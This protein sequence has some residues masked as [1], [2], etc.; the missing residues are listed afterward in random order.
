MEVQEVRPAPAATTTDAVVSALLKKRRT[1]GGDNKGAGGAAGDKGKKKLKFIAPVPPPPSLR[2]SIVAGGGGSS[3][4]GAST[5]GGSSTSTS[6]R[7]SSATSSMMPALTSFAP[8]AV[9]SPQAA[10]DVSSLFKAASVPAV[11]APP[12]PDLMER[13][14]VSERRNIKQLMLL[15]QSLQDQADMRQDTLEAAINEQGQETVREIRV[16]LAQLQKTI[17]EQQ[18][19]RMQSPTP[20]APTLHDRHHGSDASAEPATQG[21]LLGVAQRLVELHAEER[22]ERR[23]IATALVTLSENVKTALDHI[24]ES[25]NAILAGLAAIAEAQASAPAPAATTTPT[26]ATGVT[27]GELL[28]PTPLAT[29]MAT[30]DPALFGL[31]P[32]AAGVGGNSS[33]NISGTTTSRTPTTTT[34]STTVRRRSAPAA[35]T[36]SKKNGGKPMW[37]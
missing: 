24:M 11:P 37:K 13:F 36:T 19:Q 18:Q 28:L 6:S 27:G 22:V 31:F 17:V 10:F 1:S 4:A 15:N 29:T 21:Q 12:H 26:T 33:S 9:P 8:A 5:G 34:V 14:M 23:Q 30:P 2:G 20:A 32:G 7:S 35:A 3:G 25:Q 16:S